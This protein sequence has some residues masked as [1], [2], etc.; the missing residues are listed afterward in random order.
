MEKEEYSDPVFIKEYAPANSK[1]MYLYFKELQLP[2]NCELYS[3]AHGNNL[4]SLWFI[5]KIP[6]DPNEQ[7]SQKAIA[8]MESI[9]KGI[10]VY[11]TLG[12]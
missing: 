1:Q 5:W 12:R 10:N 3:Y 7:N 6:T 8:L 9:E 2:F 11:M 4:W